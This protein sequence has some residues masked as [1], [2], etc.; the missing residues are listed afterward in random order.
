MSE[1][2]TEHGEGCG[3]IQSFGFDEGPEPTLWLAEIEYCPLHKAAPELMEALEQCLPYVV[4]MPIEISIKELRDQK[5]KVMREARD[6][7]RQAK[8]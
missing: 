7:I 8:E 2:T 6:A 1:H 5:I 4:S 3:C